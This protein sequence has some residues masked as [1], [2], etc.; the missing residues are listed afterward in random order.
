MIVICDEDEEEDCDCQAGNKRQLCRWNWQDLLNR[1][2]HGMVFSSIFIIVFITQRILIWAS[3]IPASYHS[4]AP[5]SNFKK[6]PLASRMISMADVANDAA[7]LLAIHAIVDFQELNDGFSKPFVSS[8]FEY[9]TASTSKNT[10]WFWLIVVGF[11]CWVVFLWAKSWAGKFNGRDKISRIISCIPYHRSPERGLY[12]LHKRSGS[13]HAVCI[14]S[15]RVCERQASMDNAFR[16]CIVDYLMNL[17]EQRLKEM[18][19]AACVYM[20]WNVAH[21]SR[22]SLTQF[23]P[24]DQGVQS[25]YDQLVVYHPQSWYTRLLA[26][27][28]FRVVLRATLRGPSL[29]AE[30]Y[31]PNSEGIDV[32]DGMLYLLRPR[33]KGPTFAKTWNH[34]THKPQDWSK[35]QESGNGDRSR[36][37]NK[38]DAD[39]QV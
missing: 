7:F 39:D 14:V 8:L 13:K 22:G 1:K 2:G 30:L 33:N 25:D 9:V 10:G 35:W 17:N 21:E 20:L 34:H 15:S 32:T 23:T 6:R 16:R 11:Y 19:S 29:N 18:P 28:A 5:L 26:H 38:N 31:Y 3:L 24:N 4:W 36:G 27:W 37:S 12:E